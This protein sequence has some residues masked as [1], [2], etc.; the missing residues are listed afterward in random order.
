MQFANGRLTTAARPRLNKSSESETALAARRP[1]NESSSPMLIDALVL[2]VA[3][4]SRS[5]MV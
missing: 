4:F 5:M 1:Y 3:R 2:L